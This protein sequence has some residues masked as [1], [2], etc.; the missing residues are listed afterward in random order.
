V[1]PCRPYL[2]LLR[3]EVVLVPPHE[4][5]Q[6]AIHI[7]EDQCELLNLGLEDDLLQLHD[8]GVA[9]LLENRDLPHGRTGHSLI[10]V[11]QFYLLQG[12]DLVVCGVA[13]LVDIAIGAL[14]DLL[15]LL[16]FVTTLR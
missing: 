7:L 2:D 11:L 15:E 16:V 1:G 5:L 14:S 13:S 9:Q 12:D 3:L 6:I 4:L 8:V 10:L